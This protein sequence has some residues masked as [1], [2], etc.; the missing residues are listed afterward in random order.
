[1]FACNVEDPVEPIEDCETV[2]AGGEGCMQVIEFNQSL[3]GI[4]WFDIDIDKEGL[5][6]VSLHYSESGSH[7]SGYDF[8]VDILSRNEQTEILAQTF[9][10][11]TF[12]GWLVDTT[13]TN[14][15]VNIRFHDVH[16]CSAEYLG[17]SINSYSTR[18]NSKITALELGDTI[19]MT[20]WVVDTLRLTSKLRQTYLNQSGSSGDTIFW[21]NIVYHTDCGM[22]PNTVSYIGIRKQLPSGSYV[23]GWVKVSTFAAAGITVH[24]VAI[25]DEY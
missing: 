15:Q 18:W 23:T 9:L 6:D 16:T 24:S 8:R 13:Y 25:K 5:P 4:S 14:G 21:Q 12:R 17:D 7:G 2:V 20:G 3:P 10:D 19:P 11:T 1:M 22:L